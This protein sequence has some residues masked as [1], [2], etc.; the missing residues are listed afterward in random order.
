MSEMLDAVD[1]LCAF[2]VAKHEPGTPTARVA[3]RIATYLEHA[4][5]GLSLK[6]ALGLKPKRGGNSW[7]EEERTR[8]RHE[9]IARLRDLVCVGGYT[10]DATAIRAAVVRYKEGRWRFDSL[11]PKAPTADDTRAALHALLST[12]GG[13]IPSRRSIERALAVCDRG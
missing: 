10:S 8:R 11:Q 1:D 5:G 12:T 13:E 4:A 2:A 3:E 7:R 9:A 6:E